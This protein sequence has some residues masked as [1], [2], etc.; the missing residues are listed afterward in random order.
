[1]IKWYVF[2]VA[3]VLVLLIMSLCI[4]VDFIRG[5]TLEKLDKYLFARFGYIKKKRQLY[6]LRKVINELA[7]YI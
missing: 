4:I 3:F 7:K 5:C 6:R 1:M 2:G